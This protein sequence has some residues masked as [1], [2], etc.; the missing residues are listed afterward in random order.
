MRVTI[1]SQLQADLR[2]QEFEANQRLDSLKEALESEAK[3]T[4]GDKH[5]TGRA[6]I[7]QE[8]AQ[9]HDTLKRVERHHADLQ[10]MI[11]SGRIPLRVATGVLVETDGPWVLLG[12]GLGRLVVNDQEV[13]AI[14]AEAPLA[15][16]LQGCKEGDEV[17]VGAQTWVIRHLH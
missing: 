4:A 5:E 14:S 11:Q 13:L 6:M 9:V 3:S 7:H 15:R 17:R 10:R 1:L 2:R 8:M 12:L 16:Q